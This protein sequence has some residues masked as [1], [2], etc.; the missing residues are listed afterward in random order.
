MMMMYTYITSG[1]LYEDIYNIF[2]DILILRIFLYL[3]IYIY[4]D[5]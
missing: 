5:G 2:F 1:I 3:Y 4:I